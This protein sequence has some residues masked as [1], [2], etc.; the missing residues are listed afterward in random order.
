M[1]RLLRPF[2]A[3]SWHGHRNDPDLPDAVRTVWREKFGRQSGNG[4]GLRRKQSNVD[5]AVLDAKGNLVHWFDGFRRMGGQS[6]P[7]GQR[8]ESLGDYTARELQKATAELHLAGTPTEEHPLK[9]PDPGRSGMRVFISLLEERM[10]AYRAPVV[11]AVNL[12]RN[13]WKPLAYPDR[14]KNIEAS[15]LK[16]WLSQVYPPGVMERTDPQTKQVY[17]ISRIKGNLTLEPAGTFNNMRYALLTGR[18]ILT[19]EGPDDFS[20]EGDIE[21]VLTYSKTRSMPQS[22]RGIFDGIYP[23]YNPMNRSFR[24]IPLQAAFEAL[25]MVDKN[26]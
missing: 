23:R 1:V 25:P 12:T 3:A 15:L 4:P 17:R 11:E 16:K 14:E 26:P 5:L 20:Y 18:I 9:L 2:I 21:I 8:H 6:F 10:R 24:E 19:D 22:L 7:N 13:D